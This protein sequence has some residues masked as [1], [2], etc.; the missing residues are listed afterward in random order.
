M[1]PKRKLSDFRQQSQNLNKH[2]PRGM[3]ML[4][5]SM[6]EVGY[7]GPMVAAADGEIIDGSARHETA[8]NVFGP[9]A[10]P[11]I[12]ESD[13]KRPV[14]VV[15]KDIPNAKTRMA[16]RLAAFANRVGQVNL[17][18]E[19]DVVREIV[20]EDAEAFK[21]MFGEDEFA[22][23][24]ARNSA[25]STVDAEPQ[26]DRRDELR[27]KW[28]VKV[29]DLWLIGEHRLLCGDSTKA[30]DVARLLG[31]R[32]PVLMVTD[33]PYGVEYDPMFRAEALG[34]AV[35]RAGAVANDD[36]ADWSE[37]WRLFTGDVLYCW[38]GMRTATEVGASLIASAFEVRAEI[39]W[40]KARVPF[41]RGHYHAGHES[42]FYA[43]RKGKEARWDGPPAE[44]TVWK[45]DI[46]ATADGGHGT[47]KPIECMARP[48]RNHDAPEVYDPFCGS[49]TSI[50]AAEQLGRKCYAIEI[51][52]GYVAVILQRYLDATGKRP[53]A[54]Q[55]VP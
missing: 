13:G 51:E 4:E 37:A 20:A 23:L 5:E 19:I 6:Q 44:S 42:C 52:P 40:V 31:D 18:G 2:T 54:S 46:D 47:Q 34:A 50:I 25:E 26:V 33:P 7:A 22:Q 43:V 11:I 38:H 10:E 14:V 30:A 9:D 27:E 1:K 24:L 21:G 36:R 8:A 53:I 15:R 49:G 48:M 3:G 55:P 41:G 45:L 39:V 12:V 17:E 32:K 35:R 29:G 28:G 16:R